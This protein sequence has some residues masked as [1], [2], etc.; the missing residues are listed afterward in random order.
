MAVATEAAVSSM[1]PD[2][3][4]KPRYGICMFV[5]VRV[6]ERSYLCGCLCKFLTHFRSGIAYWPTSKDH[7]D[8]Y[9]K[10]L[11]ASLKVAF[12]QSMVPIELNGETY[13]INTIEMAHHPNASNIHEHPL[14]LIHGFG[15]GIGIFVK[16]LDALSQRFKV[17]AFD[18]LGFGKS[19]RPDFPTDPEQVENLFIDS[20]EAW[21]KS[22]N[23]DK[24]VLL[25][26]SFGGYQA[27]CYA[28]KYPQHV[29]HL[30]L[31]DPWGFPVSNEG[32]ATRRQIPMWVK[33]V[34]PMLRQFSPF[35]LLRYA[36]RFKLPTPSPFCF[37]ILIFC[38]SHAAFL[39][40]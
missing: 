21:R 14:V 27:A 1:R 18:T 26:H 32:S 7:L 16:N 28:I 4:P 11:L 40:L 29:H 22:M 9:E 13:Q 25:G 34:A 31:A 5:L 23:L 35:A 38:P 12:K 3:G 30:I 37:F 20:I 15:G 33:V 24:I 17:Y 19:S 10:A 39:L 2:L 8:Y 6:K 36:V